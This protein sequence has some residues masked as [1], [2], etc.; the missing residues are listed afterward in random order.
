MEEGREGG[1][2]GVEREERL[3]DGWVGRWKEG[4][5]GGWMKRWMDG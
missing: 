1:M 5:M 4:W 2:E 3:Q